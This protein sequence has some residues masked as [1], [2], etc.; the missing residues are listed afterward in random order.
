[1]MALRSL[2][3]LAVLSVPTLAHLKRSKKPESAKVDEVI[4]LFE[5]G[6]VW[7]GNP[8]DMEALSPQ[9]Q[10]AV[11]A[12][13]AQMEAAPGSPCPQTPCVGRLEIVPKGQ[14]AQHSESPMCVPKE[15]QNSADIKTI[16]TS[17]NKLMKKVV[18]DK[19]EDMDSITM[20]I[21]CSSSGG[22]DKGH[23]GDKEITPDD[24][25]IHDAQPLPAQRHPAAP[26]TTYERASAF[27]LAPM[28]A[29]VAA[30]VI[31]LI[32]L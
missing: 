14:S 7:R 20:E 19:D 2:C 16:V 3:F 8:H 29:G 10:K 5:Q 30:C 13:Q 15:C 24:D 32:F 23:G 21:D 22:P 1:M 28:A 26:R 11:K 4:K 27:T 25:F 18:S 9:C 12:A 6:R 17:M 31:N